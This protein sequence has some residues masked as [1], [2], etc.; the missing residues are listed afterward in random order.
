MS[1]AWKGRIDTKQTA[2]DGCQQD[3]GEIMV[4]IYDIAK[5]VGV[6]ASAVSYVL[7]G[8]ADKAR[9][10]RRSKADNGCGKQDGIHSEYDRA[11]AESAEYASPA[12]DSPVLVAGTASHVPE[13]IHRYSS[14]Y[15]VE[16]AGPAD[17]VHNTAVPEW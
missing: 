5:A 7:S 11:Q 2:I 6:S 14:G 3:A 8:R 12:G 16:R 15:D 9:I 1:F 10:S 4:S 17:A 13:Y